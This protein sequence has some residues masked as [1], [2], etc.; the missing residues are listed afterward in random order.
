[1]RLVMKPPAAITRAG[2]AIPQRSRSAPNKQ[3][4]AA[5]KYP[6]PIRSFYD[7]RRRLVRDLSCGG[8]RVYLDVEVRRVACRSCASAK[9]ERW[10]LA[11]NPFYTKRFAFFVGRRC[12]IST[13]KDVAEELHLHWESVKTL[14]KQYMRAQLRRIGTPAPPAIGIDEISIRK[15]HTYR[16]V[17]SDLDRMRPIWFG[18]KDR[19]E[20]SM[21]LDNLTMA[22][23]GEYG[24]S[25]PIYR[26]AACTLCYLK[27]F[28]ST[29]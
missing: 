8:A 18:G 29:S 2:L 27:L 23:R 28:Q 5:T 15:G 12:R 3:C 7:R 22:N 20:A 17:V 11:D 1:M 24:L 6:G 4:T 26:S 13:I 19:S 21:D 10:W 25:V 9:R 14:E 16:I